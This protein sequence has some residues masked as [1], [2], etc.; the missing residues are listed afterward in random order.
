MDDHQ[1][2][3]LSKSSKYLHRFSAA[4]VTLILSLALLE[5]MSAIYFEYFSKFYYRPLYLEENDNDQWRTEFEPWGAWHKPNAKAF[6]RYL[7][8]AV[9]Y[10]SNSIGARDIERATPGKANSVI[11]LG[12]SFI[13]G[14]GVGDEE[15]VSNIFEQRTGRASINLGSALDFGPLQYFMLYQA[16][17]DRFLHDAVVIGF[18]PANDFTDND[19][20]YEEWKNNERYRPYYRKTAS[21]YEI[22][23]KGTSRTF[24]SDETP[25]Y[26]EGISAFFDRVSDLLHYRKSVL[27][28]YAWTG[29]F[30]FAIRGQL[31]LRSIDISRDV[32][33]S[34]YFETSRERLEATYYFLQR[35]IQSASGAKIYILIIPTYSEAKEL[36][37][38]SSPWLSEFVTKFQS[39]RVTIIDLGPIFAGLSNDTLRSA[40]L[41]CN[42]HWSALGNA[43]AADALLKAFARSQP[44]S[45][46]AKAVSR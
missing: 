17:A 34:G 32:S 45:F 6:Q 15:R 27:V 42:G 39:E 38:R 4:L 13:E 5:F 36:R 23:H 2:P 29:G 31:P 41:E 44:A 46:E 7:C 28:H 3:T 26:P 22:F 14:L 12:D 35:I 43:I 20:E 25:L 33:N 40:F 1:V 16:L 11:F 19:P 21:G 37:V 10:T 24:A 9:T 30:L 8:F 18:L